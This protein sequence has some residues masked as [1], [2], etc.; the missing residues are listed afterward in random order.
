MSRS[1][2]L[3]VFD[4]PGR[5][6]LSGG[7]EFSH[8][9]TEEVDRYLVGLLTDNRRVAFL[10]TA[11]GSSEYATQFG[12]YLSGID[13]TIEVF[14]VPVYRGRDVRRRR[15][16]ESIS[17]AGLVYL[18]GG[19]VNHVTDTIKGSPIEEA[20][21]KVVATGGV[22]AATGG[23]AASFG[24]LARSMLTV[25]AQIEGMGWLEKTMIEP[26]FSGEASRILQD[27]VLTGRVKLGVGLP[28]GTAISIGPGG[29]TDV[30]GDGDIAILRKE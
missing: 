18:G 27:A 9:H 4:F 21:R 11:S 22:I 17:G 20:L 3:P 30:I 1:L 28:H 23:A 16:I 29:Q 7:G 8:G 24:A 2:E 10:P 19:V 14:N 6:V 25:G 15:N 13:D 5:L 26:G 12:R